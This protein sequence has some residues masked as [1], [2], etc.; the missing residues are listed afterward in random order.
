MKNGRK[1]EKVLLT[2]GIK[3]PV[4]DLHMHAISAYAIR[5]GLSAEITESGWRAIPKIWSKGVKGG[6][7]FLQS[8]GPSNIG[9]QLIARIKGCN[10][11]YYLHEPTPWRV[12]VNNGDGL[13]KSTAMQFVQW[14]DAK[15]STKIFVSRSDLADSASRIYNVDTE[16]FELAPLLMIEAS[17]SEDSVIQRIT[18][19]GR[20][21]TRR[22]L[23]EFVRLSRQFRSNGLHPTILTGQP[24][25]LTKLLNGQDISDVEI[26]AQHRFPESL[27]QKILGETRIIW[28]PKRGGIAQS[29][30]TADAIRFGTQ[31]ILTPHDPEYQNL[32]DL[33]LALDMDKFLRTDFEMSNVLPRS[34]VLRKASEIFSARHGEI[35]FNK[36]YLPI[37]SDRATTEN[38]D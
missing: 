10:I 29:G 4:H 6:K 28:N 5:S 14:F 13:I 35:A 34:T 22:Y 18:Y 8:T 17:P 9:L 25:T 38:S 24:D 11:I 12:K 19:V 16:K 23:L 3:S 21:D 36:F 15:L 30:V 26:I 32:I 33:E 1:E 20:P 37:L 2:S 27:K 31:I 7:I